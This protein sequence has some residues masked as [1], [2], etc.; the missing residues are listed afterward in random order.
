MTLDELSVL[1]TAD[2]SPLSQAVA[3]AVQLLSQAGNQADHLAGQFAAAGVQAGQ[4]LQSGLLSQQ[5]RVAAAARALADAASAGLKSA[6]RI[7]SP[8]RLTYEVGALFDQ[9]L[10]DGIAAGAD[11]AAREAADLGSAAA[12]ALRGTEIASPL[13]AAPAPA[14]SLADTPRADSALQSLSL[15]IPLEIDGYR[16]GVA[17][18]EGINQ[19]TQGTGRVELAL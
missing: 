8:S 17:A 2:V 18:I 15:T 19:V 14:A 11:R 7:H 12:S 4:G 10:L 16:L 6:L 9:G 1:F 5:S 13:F 3:Q